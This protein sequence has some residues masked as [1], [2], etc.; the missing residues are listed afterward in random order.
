MNSLNRGFLSFTKDDL[1][2]DEKEAK[3]TLSR[4]P[5]LED[6]SK[7]WLSKRLGRKAWIWRTTTQDT[8]TLW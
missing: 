3:K 6:L 8:Y 5:Q 2:E 1:K 4:L 7:V